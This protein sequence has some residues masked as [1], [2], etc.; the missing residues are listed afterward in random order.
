MPPGTVTPVPRVARL[1]YD[2]LA[3]H[4]SAL[5]LR[6]ILEA[7]VGWKASRLVLT[8][9]E[10]IVAAPIL[11]RAGLAV[12]ISEQRYRSL[13][14]AS[15]VGWSHEPAPT[16]ESDPEG[17]LYLYVATDEARMV[18]A[19]A[20]EADGD[21]ER[22]GVVLDIPACCRLSFLRMQPMRGDPL[23]STARLGDVFPLEGR[24]TNGAAGYVGYGLLSFAPC[25]QSCRYAARRARRT[26]RLLNALSVE[27][28]Q[29]FL[30]AHEATYLWSD[31]Q[32]LHTLVGAKR[33]AGV[34]RWDSL[35]SSIESPL[36]TCLLA[37]TGLRVSRR[38]G[39][40]VRQ[41]GEWHGLPQDFGAVALFAGGLQ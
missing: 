26:W 8:E 20:A 23:L 3:P 24:W 28:A 30:K 34:V 27:L 2:Q 10:V 41:V 6:E 7:T 13:P 33:E 16:L 4:V 39:V 5:S 15:V 38:D 35:R 11:R 17:R 19:A 32:G 12:G 29:R 25:R 14:S 9:A 18:E 40:E 1:V 21:A 22:F 37:S 36:S 31:H